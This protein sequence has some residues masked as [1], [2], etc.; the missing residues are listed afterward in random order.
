MTRTPIGDYALLSDCHSAVLVSKHGSVDW[1]CFPRFD[2][3]SV[4][5][6]LLDVDGGHWSLRPAGEASVTRRYRD[7]T[8]VLETRFESSSGAMT[9]VDARARW[10]LGSVP[11]TASTPGPRPA[12]T[13][14]GP[15]RSGRGARGSGRSPRRSTPTS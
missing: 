6:R 2:S 7:G 9:V 12:R 4:F 1:L 11:R 8:M 5:G 10:R 3:P 15:S 13:S 14:G